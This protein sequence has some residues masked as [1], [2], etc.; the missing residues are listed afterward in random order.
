MNGKTIF[1]VK[2]EIKYVGKIQHL[3]RIIKRF[4][5]NWQHILKALSFIIFVK[6]K[7]MIKVFLLTLAI[8]GIA[9][10]GMAFNLIFR[11]K[12][13]PDTHV[14]HNKEMKKKGIVCAKTMDKMEQAK[15]KEAIRFK[16]L[17]LVKK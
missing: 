6:K 3:E 13:F 11:K 10:I 9:F 8:V 5:H 16:N 7:S 17:T 2:T 14:G 15:A 4:V 12:M 1:S